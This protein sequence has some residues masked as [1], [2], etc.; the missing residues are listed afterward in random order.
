M[1]VPAWKKKRAQRQPAYA[2]IILYLAKISILIFVDMAELVYASV[3]K[4][5]G[6]A[7]V[8][9]SPTIHTIGGLHLVYCHK[10]KQLICT[11]YLIV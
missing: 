1:W 5:G 4:S 6:L 3:S 2:I 11:I 10:N 8:G 7:H 9:S